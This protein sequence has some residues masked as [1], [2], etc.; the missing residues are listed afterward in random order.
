[1]QRSG[2]FIYMQNNNEQSTKQPEWLAKLT[3]DSRNGSNQ[4]IPDQEFIILSVRI[5]QDAMKMI[6]A[7]AYDDVISKA[8]YPKIKKV[9]IRYFDP[10]I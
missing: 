6:A 8:V 2:F 3:N 10:I 9:Y 7:G 5:I 4:T 1:M